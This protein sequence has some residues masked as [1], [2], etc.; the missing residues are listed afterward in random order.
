MH[1]GKLLL[2]PVCLLGLAG[3]IDIEYVGQTYGEDPERHILWYNSEQEVPPDTYKVAGRATA[4]CGS[5]RTNDDVRH[6]LLEEAARRGVD[7]VQ[8]VKTDLK[9][10]KRTSVNDSGFA[11][12]GS[13][14]RSSQRDG[15]WSPYDSFG[16]PS[17][18]NV[19]NV[20]IQRFEAKVLFLVKTHRYEEAM[21]EFEAE[22]RPVIETTP[23]LPEKTA[24]QTAP[25]ETPADG[26]RPIETIQDL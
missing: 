1:L 20:S 24:P 3:C 22:R 23:L 17:S 7:A 25:G 13:N 26:Q 4:S 21:R 15:V 14:Q 18:R 6:A 12:F 10:V 8:V 11:Q 9:T 5:D 16:Q 2:L 19:R